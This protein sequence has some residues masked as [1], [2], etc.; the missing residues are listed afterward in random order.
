MGCSDHPIT[1]RTFLR[2]ASISAAA[3]TA[4]LGCD[5]RPALPAGIVEL[6]FYTF[7]GPEFRRLFHE[8][9]TPAFL[10]SHPDIRIR[11]NESMGD[12]GYEA[13]LLMLIA[14]K[15]APDLFRVHQQNFPFYAAKGILLPLDDFLDDDE[16]ISLADFDPQLLDGMRYNGKLLG[17][18]TDFSP[19]AILYNKDLFDR[20]NVPHPH[21]NWT[22]DDFLD[23]ARRLTRDTDGD[24]H[25]DM[26]GFATIDSY[27]RWPAWVWNNGGEILSADGKRCLMDGAEAIEGLRL[28]VDLAR[29]QKVSPT[30]GPTPGLS[31]GQEQSDLFASRRVAMIAESRYIYKRLIG[32]RTLPFRWDVAPMPKRR[33]QVTTFIWGGNCMLK[34]TKHPRQAWEFLKFMSGPAGAAINRQAGNALPAYR[35][36]A[37]G[38]IARPSMRGIPAH[39]RCVLDA[40][41]YGRAAPFPPQYAEFTEAMTLLRDAFLG[42]RTVD[43]ACRRFTE[44]VNTVLASGV[45]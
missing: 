3:A 36:A 11:V 8:Q 1:R 15:L 26:F 13:K 42:L 25:T 4:V 29:R 12:A 44:E 22:T 17:L 20:F 32:S 19:I 40:I 33:S 41:S 5:R 34:S 21:P 18:P 43:D 39:D 14:G 6:D 24:G 45:F 28:Y 10:R 23:A 37:I 27:N 2:T 9:L 38:E 30:P 35:P 31:M 7:S 16:E